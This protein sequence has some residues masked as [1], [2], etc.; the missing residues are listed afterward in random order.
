MPPI[1]TGSYIMQHRTESTFIL[2]SGVSSG[3]L[4]NLLASLHCFLEWHFFFPSSH[5]FFRGQ[6]EFEE[7]LL[8]CLLGKQSL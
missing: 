3:S 5:H 1:I 2:H 6:G 4:H 7:R 8:L